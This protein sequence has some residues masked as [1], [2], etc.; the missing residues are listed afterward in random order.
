MTGRLM[1]PA[2]PFRIEAGGVARAAGHAKV[3]D[4][5]RHLLAGRAGERVMLRDYGTAVPARL[6]EP[7]S[8]ALAPLLRRDIERA[9]ARFMPEVRLT[10]PVRV[11]VDGERLTVAVEYAVR[12]DDVVRRLEL[13]LP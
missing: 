13:D 6:Q 4:G 10:A 12:P 3:E 11:T 5:L 9:L 2:F 8:A 1:G 7:G